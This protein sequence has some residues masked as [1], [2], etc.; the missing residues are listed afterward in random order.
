[1]NRCGTWWSQECCSSPT[2]G[3][4]S[5]GAR[6]SPSTSPLYGF[7]RVFTE[8]LRLDPSYDVFGPIRFN[9]AGAMLICVAGIVAF[10]RLRKYR[11]GRESVEFGEPSAGNQREPR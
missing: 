2:S 7:G 5:A 8:H 1:M 3:S 9:E 10:G 4:A 6:C 11:P